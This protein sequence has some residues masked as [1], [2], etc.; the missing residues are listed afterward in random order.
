MKEFLT[1]IITILS[2]VFKMLRPG[3]LKSLAAENIAIKQQLLLIKRKEKITKSPSLS[4]LHRV[5]EF[6]RES[7]HFDKNDGANMMNIYPNVK[8]KRV[9]PSWLSDVQPSASCF[10]PYGVNLAISATHTAT[11][12]LKSKGLK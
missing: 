9:L 10:G 12:L 1:L 5:L 2:T 6:P 4:P 8:G 7:G 3:G 11:S